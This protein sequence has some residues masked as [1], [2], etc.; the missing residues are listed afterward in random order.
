MRKE[1][2]KKNF[3]NEEDEANWWDQNQ[4]AL[5]DE[6][7]RATAEETLGHGT[8]ARKGATPTTTIRLAPEDILLARTQAEKRGLR[9]QTYLKMVIHEALRNEE[10]QQ[11]SKPARKASST[12]PRLAYS[13]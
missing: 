12:K 9:Y 8:V 7:E 4:D 5:A 6:F 1:F 2:Q 11:K 3:K 13:R 10:A